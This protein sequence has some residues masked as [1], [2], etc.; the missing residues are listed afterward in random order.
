LAWKL[1]LR[2]RRDLGSREISGQA[3]DW[4]LPDLS[5]PPRVDATRRVDAPSK[6]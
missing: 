5:S 2:L 1:R 6:R 4:L 3:T